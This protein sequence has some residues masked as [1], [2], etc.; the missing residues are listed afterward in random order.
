VTQEGD[1]FEIGAVLIGLAVVAVAIYGVINAAG[2]RSVSPVKFEK[3]S[4]YPQYHCPGHPITVQWAA[5]GNP[6]KLTFNGKDQSLGPSGTYE[7]P[8]SLVDAAPDD[9]TVIMKIEPN[10]ETLSFEVHTIRGVKKYERRA[11]KT[12]TP[13]KYDHDF[14]IGIW[15]DDILFIGIELIEPQSYIK[16]GK[17]IGCDWQYDVGMEYTGT[18]NPDNNY[19]ESFGP[20]KLSSARKWVFRLGNPP[21]N[22]EGAIGADT[23]PKFKVVVRCNR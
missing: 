16:A 8:A 9:A 20:V 6:V 3:C 21:I 2:G 12:N 5:Q 11:T 19:V 22:N 15:T 7:I 10:G 4:V 1:M 14:P 13:F 23:A 17:T 18:L